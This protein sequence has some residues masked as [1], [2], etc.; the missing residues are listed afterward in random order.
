MLTSFIMM[1]Q[2]YC[3]D[4]C[5]SYKMKLLQDIQSEMLNV[6][7][8]RMIWCEKSQ[9]R[10]E[11]VSRS[12]ASDSL[13]PHGPQPTRLLCW[14][15]SPGQ[16]TEGVSP[17]LLQGIFL[18]Q[19]SNPGLPHCRQILYHLSHQG[20]PDK[21]QGVGFLKGVKT[22]MRGYSLGSVKGLRCLP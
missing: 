5:F 15:N 6:I 16:N 19:G 14:W 1:E 12:V 7:A 4:V 8:G 21:S 2:D 3:G 11:S 10:S 20:K 13:W 17:S 22:E 9:K 18:T